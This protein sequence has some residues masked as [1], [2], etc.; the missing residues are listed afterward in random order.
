MTVLA[1]EMRATVQWFSQFSSVAQLCTTLRN[2]MDCSMP[3]SLSNASTR[4]YSNSC[5]LSQWCH[6]TISSSVV[7]CS[8]HLQSFPA[9]PSFLMSQFFASGGQSI[10]LSAS[11][12]VLPGLISFRMDWLDLLVKGCCWTTK[13]TRILGLWRR[14]IQSRARDE[15]WSLRAF[16]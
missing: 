13:D 8:C 6:P 5:P 2:P 1:W 4:V 10:G 9:I 11:E 16:M 15:T 12:S 7:P 14:R 3:G